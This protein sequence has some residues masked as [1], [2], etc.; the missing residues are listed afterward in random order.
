MTLKDI[1]QAVAKNVSIEPPTT[2]VSNNE[3]DAVKLLQFANEAGQELARRV[4]WGGLRKSKTIIGTGFAAL[5]DLP[6]DYARMVEGWGITCD[7]NPVR[8][9]LTADEWNALAPAAGTPRYYQT[10]GAAIGFYPYPPEGLQLV[11][12]YI[13]TGWTS[14]GN[15]AFAADTDST[16]FPERLVEL[17]TTW[18]FRRHIGADFSDFLAEFEAALQDFARNDGMVRQP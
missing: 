14:T 1:A 5:F 4:D 13:G 9:G 12:S 2:V 17:G 16:V 10:V 8:G 18:R 3:P 6:A 15:A 7:G 11:L